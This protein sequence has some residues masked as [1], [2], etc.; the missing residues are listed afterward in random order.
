M[1]GEK[2]S[3]AVATY[4]VSI[5]N[6]SQHL[7]WQNMTPY[8]K[9][10]IRAAFKMESC[11]RKLVLKEGEETRDGSGREETVV[12]LQKKQRR[13]VSPLGR[14]SLSLSEKS[15]IIHQVRQDLCEDKTPKH[16]LSGAVNAIE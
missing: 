5:T 4:T 14:V 2:I 13:F 11:K 6:K 12:K 7:F 9:K 15:L 3:D 16:K 8:V 1:S 10:Q